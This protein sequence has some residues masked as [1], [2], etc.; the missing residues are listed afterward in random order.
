M[1][2]I[3][4]RVVRAGRRSTIGNRVM[5]SKVSEGS[6]PLLSAKK[7][8]FYRLFFYKGFEQGGS[9]AEENSP[10]DCFR[11]RGNERSEAIEPAGSEKS[12]ALRQKRRFLPSFF[13]TRDSKQKQ[14]LC[15]Q[16]RSCRYYVTEGIIKAG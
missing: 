14:R 10:V 3:I 6:N 15:R 2:V 5:L 16:D 8:G 11:R 1:Q 7:D 13:F 4:W 12:L 9:E